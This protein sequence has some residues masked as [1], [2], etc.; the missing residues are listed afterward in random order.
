[1]FHSTP[2]TPRGDHI[3]TRARGKIASNGVNSVLGSLRLGLLSG[4]P[5]G[6][7]TLE[8]SRALLPVV[9]DQV[10]GGGQFVASATGRDDG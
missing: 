3:C 5:R 2:R 6:L 9:R 1:M 8:H 4:V 7:P 10:Q